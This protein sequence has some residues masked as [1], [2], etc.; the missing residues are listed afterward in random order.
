M[1]KSRLWRSLY[2]WYKIMLIYTNFK[3]NFLTKYHS[4]I[5]NCLKNTNVLVKTFI[6]VLIHCIGH[7]N[8]RLRLEFRSFGVCVSDTTRPLMLYI[9]S[10]YKA[11][12]LFWKT[13]QVVHIN[14]SGWLSPLSHFQSIM[15]RLFRFLSERPVFYPK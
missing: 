4:F 9:N 14:I 6:R 8:S 1:K 2:I 13:R 10:T 15:S 3:F 5:L 12:Q 11:R 7:T